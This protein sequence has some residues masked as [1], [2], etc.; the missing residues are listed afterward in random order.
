MRSEKFELS[1]SKLDCLEV[2]QMEWLK[3]GLAASEDESIV[4]QWR[5]ARLSPAPSC[6]HCQTEGGE[7]LGV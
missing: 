3:I 7:A 2:G 5:E 4:V 1:L 6:V